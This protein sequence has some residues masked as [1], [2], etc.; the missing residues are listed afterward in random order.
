M[1]L[2]LGKVNHALVAQVLV[3]PLSLLAQLTRLGSQASEQDLPPGAVPGT[4]LCAGAELADTARGGGSQQG[5][6]VPMIDQWLQLK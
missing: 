5:G 1:H 3:L 2:S 6:T 4:P